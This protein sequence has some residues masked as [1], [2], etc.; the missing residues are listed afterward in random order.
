MEQ[1][2]GAGRRRLYRQN[3]CGAWPGQH[4]RPASRRS[5]DALRARGA[6]PP[7][8]HR[9]VAKKVEGPDWFLNTTAAV[10]TAEDEDDGALRLLSDDELGRH[11]APVAVLQPCSPASTPP[12]PVRSSPTSRST[13]PSSSPATTPWTT[14]RQI[15]ADEVLSRHEPE[16]ALQILLDHCGRSCPVSL[17]LP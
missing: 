11:P 12:P 8:G 9:T 4:S 14:L 16:I 17:S 7:P 5:A 15:P 2:A 3:A 1:T 13:G 6:A 10:P